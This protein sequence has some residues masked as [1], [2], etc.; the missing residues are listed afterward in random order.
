MEILRKVVD[1]DSINTIKS[2]VKG[3]NSN[4]TI[5]DKH[6]E[7]IDKLIKYSNI[8][9]CDIT[10]EKLL[11]TLKPFINPNDFKHIYSIHWIKYESE[12]ECL[13]HIDMESYTT[14]I[15]NLNDGFEG[16]ELFVNGIN[17]QSKQGDIVIFNGMKDKHRVSKITKGIR[18]V[19][20]VWI[21]P[22]SKLKGLI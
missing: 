14:Y 22:T 19:L 11:N 15:L 21:S 4:K 10:N 13:E 18:E 2:V 1:I 8:H 7:Y 12:Y 17:T 20:V 16:G 5:V 6:S 3:G 9:Y